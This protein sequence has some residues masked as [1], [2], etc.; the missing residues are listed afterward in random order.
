MRA[1]ARVLAALALASCA[2]RA[3]TLEELRQ[4]AYEAHVRQDNTA[5]YRLTL[6]ALKL[7]PDDS[8]LLFNMA[9]AA[10][11]TGRIEESARDLARALE[12]GLDFGCRENPDLAALR[13]S[14][15][16]ETEIRPLL[17]RLAEP[18]IGSRAAFE[19]RE[20]D[21]LT[22][23]IAYDR[24]TRA[25]FVSS[26]RRRKIVR[27]SDDGT[28]TDF[29]AEGKDG[30]G[31]VLALAADAR[32]RILW[33]CS[34]QLPQMKGYDPSRPGSTALYAFGLDD[35]RLR[36]RLLLPKGSPAGNLNDLAI[37]GK[38]RA[39]ASDGRTG[40]IYRSRQGS[41]RLEE[42]LAPG[43][44]RSAQG[45]AFSADGKTLYVA[46]YGRGLF[47]LD[48]ASG[49]LRPLAAPPGTTLVGI[50]GLVRAGRDLVA[51]QNL[52]F[53]NRV[54]RI[55]LD[56]TGRRISGVEVLER[57]NPLY[58]EPTL[59]VVVGGDFYFIARSQWSA[60][61]AKTGAADP[62]KLQ[63]PLVLSLSIR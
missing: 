44:L 27:R 57:A 62:G 54:V 40:A 32:R 56:R 6:E 31:A 42:L 28:V 19:L 24:T 30:I 39:C 37:D 43:R 34:A 53:P 12:S 2:A 55:R 16:F 4:Q 20:R 52:F 11:R 41:D 25:F 51:T 18:R 23:G 1:L 63:A 47:A 35:G 13:A 49:A 48:L 9:C 38:G 61:D 17:R 46:D 36:R 3:V 7:A 33:A 29:I 50:D 14:P 10:S 45:M 22:E 15:R 59:G 58:A 60:F 8:I 26:V 21:L 5:F